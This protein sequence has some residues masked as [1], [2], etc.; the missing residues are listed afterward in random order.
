[1]TPSVTV[2]RRRKHGIDY[3]EERFRGRQYRCTKCNALFPDSAAIERH[4]A[5]ENPVAPVHRALPR[6]DASIDV[7]VAYLA[8]LGQWL[9]E[10]RRRDRA[11]RRAGDREVGKRRIT[12]RRSP[13]RPP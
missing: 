6:F 3:L 1:V 5:R 8:D 11:D 7:R 12:P 4:V 10:R 9:G 13:P 2:I